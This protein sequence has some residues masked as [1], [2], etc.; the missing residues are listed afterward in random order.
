MTGEA[1]N[2]SRGRE[3]EAD[4]RKL[5]HDVRGC[6]HGLVLVIAALETPMTVQDRVEFLEDVERASE[7]MSE[8]M[9]KLDVLEGMPE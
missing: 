9:D 5:R 3:A 4:G 7:R 8:L 6:M 2:E 1:R